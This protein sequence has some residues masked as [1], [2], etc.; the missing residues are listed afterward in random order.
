MGCGCNKGRAR[1]AAPV[2]DRTLY[3]VVL[4][5]GNGK[6]AFQTHSLAT[7]QAVSKNY[8]GSLIDPDPEAAAAGQSPAPGTAGGA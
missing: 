2:P 5:G 4:D 6:V 1:T 8:P 3:R 7:A